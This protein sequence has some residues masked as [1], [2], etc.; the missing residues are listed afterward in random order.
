MKVC[1]KCCEATLEI[2]KANGYDLT[3]PEVVEMLLVCTCYPAGCLE[4]V[5]P[6]VEKFFAVRRP[7]GSKYGYPEL[8]N[9]NMARCEME[10][11]QAMSAMESMPCP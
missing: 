11:E 7:D 10:V 3:I 8:L 6:Q 4:D 5:R 2:A 1:K 9:V